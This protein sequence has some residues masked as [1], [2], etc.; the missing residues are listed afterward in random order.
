MKCALCFLT[1]H[2][3]YRSVLQIMIYELLTIPV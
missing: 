1:N 3:T 2:I